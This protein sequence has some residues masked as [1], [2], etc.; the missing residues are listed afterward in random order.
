MVFNPVI[1]RKHRGMVHFKKGNAD[2]IEGISVSIE[3]GAADFYVKFHPTLKA[4]A[5]SLTLSSESTRRKQRI[6]RSV[7]RLPYR[8]HNATVSNPVRYVQHLRAVRA[9]LR[10]Q[11]R[12][13]G[14]GPPRARSMGAAGASPIHIACAFACS[15]AGDE[16]AACDAD[17]HRARS[18]R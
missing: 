13:G 15:R 12:P 7:T 11:G 18:R 16:H 8:S 5:K 9:S 4:C 3:I 14:Q 1:H 10:T 6:Q 2:L 17:L